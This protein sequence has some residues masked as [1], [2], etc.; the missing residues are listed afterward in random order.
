MWLTALYKCFYLLIY[1]LTFDEHCSST[2]RL[3]GI[4]ERVNSVLVVVVSPSYWRFVAGE[5]R[6]CRRQRTG[7]C[8]PIRPVP[9][10]RGRPCTRDRHAPGPGRGAFAVAH[11]IRRRFQSAPNGLITPGLST[12]W[13]GIRI[14][15]FGRSEWISTHDNVVRLL[16]CHR[17]CHEQ[18]LSLRSE[19]R[20]KNTWKTAGEYYF[21]ED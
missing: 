10:R 19:C 6:L 7:R 17:P 16:Y 12:S 20:P 15:W 11:R 18:A 3:H 5:V 8:V 21:P 2:P 1:L 9:A 4:Y 13:T 14:A